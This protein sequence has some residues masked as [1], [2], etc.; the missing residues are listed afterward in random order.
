MGEVCKA[1]DR[2]RQGWLRRLFGF[3]SD[4]RGSVSPM[5]TLLLIP[6]IGMLGMAT[7]ASSW[8][9]A[10]RSM[11][12]AADAA[13]LAAATN[14]CAATIP[15]CVTAR[16]PYYDAEARS[17]A[18]KFGFTNGVAN[19]TV[20]ATNSAPCP[21]PAS[22]SDCYQ[23]TITRLMPLN[24]TRIVGFNGDADLDSGR[25]QSVM[26]TAI[27]SPK[28]KATYC[29]LA[30]AGGN[31]NTQGIRCNGCS[32]VDLSGCRI[33]T[34]GT[35]R[36]NGHNLNADISDAV[37]AQ[38]NC[39]VTNNTGVPKIEDPYAGLAAN[40]PSNNPC[41]P[42]NDK[43]GYPQT[44]A[45][46]PLT[47]NVTL[48]AVQQYCGNVNL[49]G[50]TTI[51]T[52]PGGSVIVIRNGRLNVGSNTLKTAAGSALTIVFT[53]PTGISGLSPSYIPAGG[54]TLD[55]AAPTSGDWSGVAIYQNPALTSGVNWSAAGNSPTWNITGLVYLPKA[56]V[57][58][59]GIVNKASVGGRSCFALVVNTF[60]SNGTTKFLDQSECPQAG[61]KPP[62]ASDYTSRTALIQ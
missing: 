37:G 7:E 13:A 10:Q 14:G 42:A 19:T 9:F 31:A 16:T 2:K 50:T 26:A 21:A 39:G 48:P 40:I 22:G 29:L 45:S 52:P 49:T 25:A 46:N 61:L 3:T 4:G 58:V 12:A 20:A 38:N 56:D 5:L 60:E 44:T 43:S 27:A 35:A 53:G 36:C 6:I 59:S 51:T 15:G 18:S 24:L 8:F 17:V 23:V 34:N 57:T 54:G 32:K 11:Q 28:S 62:T 33:G 55:F 30:L 41:T 1:K 47:G